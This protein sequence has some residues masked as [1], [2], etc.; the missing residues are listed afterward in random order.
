MHRSTPRLFLAAFAILW[1]AAILRVA[2]LSRVPPGIPFEEAAL[3]AQALHPPAPLTPG[4]GTSLM[5]YGMSGSLALF[6]ANLLGIRVVAVVCG[7]M[8]V[9]FSYRCV[10]A[11][12]G[13][14]IA[15]I[16]AAL[17][18]VSFWPLY[19]SR[20]GLE[21]ALLPALAALVTWLYARALARISG[22]HSRLSAAG[23]FGAAG[24][25]MGLA[26]YAPPGAWLMPVVFGIFYLY[27][28][29][30]RRDAL[31]A[32]PGG[33]LAFW[34]A[35]LL[36]SLPLIFAQRGI[37]ITPQMAS[38]A[39]AL[40]NGDSSALL[41]AVVRA[42]GLWTSQGDGLFHYNSAQWPAFNVALA[43]VF[44]IG[45]L[46]PL[47]GSKGRPDMASSARL[48]T[49]LWLIA[50]VAA[51][52]LNDPERPFTMGIIAMPAT[53]A[54]LGLGF[55]LLGKLVTAAPHL[56]WLAR[57]RVALM[58]AILGLAGIEG[59]WAYFVTG[60]NDRAAQGDYRSDLAA[61]ARELRSSP[62]TATV[63]IS[64]NEPHTIP[65]LIFEFLPHG[66]RNIDWFDA[67]SAL[68]VPASGAGDPAEI[69]I[70]EMAPINPRLEPYLGKPTPAAIR[71]RRYE[72]PTGEAFLAAFPSPAGPQAQVV[73][74]LTLPVQFGDAIQLFGSQSDAVRQAGK[75]VRIMLFWR[76]ARDMLPPVDLSIF[77]HLIAADGQL[78][79]QQD[80][81]GAPSVEWR[82][83]DI[84]IQIQDIVTKKTLPPGSYQLQ[85]GLYQRENGQRLPVVVDGAPVGDRLLLEPVEITA[86]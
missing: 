80:A 58:V 62:S 31:R 68:I 27:L 2:A 49:P 29:I 44:V 41:N 14:D 70:P 55:S 35:G 86:P 42:G 40:G 74:S 46:A 83:G 16:A 79:A 30:A 76:V 6:G 53:Y 57:Y 39:E 56:D 67:G 61:L 78:A 47:S 65:P 25:A 28:A 60:P 45:L 34:G 26:L 7:L 59:G 5:T 24:L 4:P 23:W 20:I 75:P 1:V 13:R 12:Y 43:T 50:G 66:Q 52:A 51:A 64:T 21:A 54:T 32:S 85:I 9:V 15:L 3:A 71:V 33:H 18:A 10:S 73:G 63:A 77:A 36:A 81:L 38:L 84:L 72:V 37:A 17:M 11:L 82:K 19:F 8:T 48:L 22:S 69:Y